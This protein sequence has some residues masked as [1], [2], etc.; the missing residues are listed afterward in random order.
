[1][2][3]VPFYEA[4]C[5][6]NWEKN[7]TNQTWNFFVVQSFQ[8]F[9]LALRKYHENSD[10]Y[11][12]SEQ[13]AL[14]IVFLWRFKSFDIP[15]FQI[16]YRPTAAE[17]D[18]R[19]QRIQKIGLCIGQQ[20]LIQIRRTNSDVRAATFMFHIASILYQRHSENHLRLILFVYLIRTI[21]W[22]V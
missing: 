13:T 10:L 18:G 6:H 20:T 8:L 21:H 19:C 3:L 16:H 4:P 1:M 14:F 2:K 11:V 5:R 22:K 17:A 15:F 9:R 12:R 7:T